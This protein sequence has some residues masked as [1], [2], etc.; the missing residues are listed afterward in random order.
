MLSICLKKE[1]V[2]QKYE[3]K[4]WQRVIFSEFA[5]TLTSDVRPFPCVFGVSGFEM[6]QLRFLFIDPT[7]YRYLS[8]A[9]T[10]YLA[11][12]RSFGPNTSLVVF[13]RPGPV[14]SIESYKKQFWSTINEIASHDTQAWPDQIPK[15]LSDPMWE[16]CFAGEAVFV[17]CNT[18][19]HIARQSRRSS[20]FMMTFQPRWV[21]EKILGT[22]ESAEKSFSKVRTRLEKYDLVEISPDLGIYG[23][24]KTLEYKQYFLNDTNDSALCPFLQLSHG[25]N[26]SYA[27]LDEKTA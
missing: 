23:D 8:N 19:A 1:E 4:S 20:S 7:D 9:L 12:A 3:S 27:I 15:N 25:E 26:I 24:K 14:Q 11:E 16:F 22:P 21:F 17:V 6:G 2:L 5:A 18:P 10:Q 13:T